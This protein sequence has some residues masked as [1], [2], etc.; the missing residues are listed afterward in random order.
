MAEFPYPL[1]QS[2]HGIHGYSGHLGIVHRWRSFLVSSIR[3][4]TESTDTQDYY[5]VYI[6]YG[7]CTYCISNIVKITSMS[8]ETLMQN[9]SQVS[10]RSLVLQRNAEI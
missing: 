9:I 10:S 1:C 4:N 6:V 7:M 5:G 2:I 3:V 8:Q